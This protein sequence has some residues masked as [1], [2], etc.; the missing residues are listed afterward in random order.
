MSKSKKRRKKKITA[1]KVEAP[2]VVKTSRFS[3]DL[4]KK[5]IPFLFPVCLAVL[6]ILF[7]LELSKNPDFEITLIQTIKWFQLSQYVLFSMLSLCFG[8]FGWRYIQNAQVMN[9]YDRY[10]F[11]IT[12]VLVFSIYVSAFTEEISINGDNAEYMIITKSIVERGKALRLEVPSETPNSLASVGLP[13][14]LAPIYKIWGFDIVK[15]KAL[16]TLMGFLIFFLLYRLFVRRQGF[17]LATMLA[18]V[19]VTSP[20]VVGNSRD[21]MTETPFLLWSIVSLIFIFKYHESKQ[22]NWKYYF[23]VFGAIIMTYLTRA[24]GASIFAALVIFLM[25]NVSWSK[26]YRPDSRKELFASIEFRKLFYMMLP[27]VIGALAWQIWQQSHGNVDIFIAS[28]STGGTIS[29]FEAFN[30]D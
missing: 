18:L 27:L 7:I 1:P 28:A 10:T 17:A 21:I 19:G 30:D 9:R 24:V 14:L 8:Y 15:M 13:L 3:S 29:G 16:I 23:L 25:S 22:L 26:I 5:W 12:S 4:I 20:Y 2:V 6:F 11:L